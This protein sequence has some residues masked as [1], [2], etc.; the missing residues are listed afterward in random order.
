[1]SDWGVGDGKLTQVVAQHLRSDL[2]LVEGLTVVDTDD[3]ANHLWDN[4][5]VSEVGA[6][7]SRL[8]V[9]GGS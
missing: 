1:M 5:H 2:D 3:R 4:D 7:D 6:N 8:L 9:L